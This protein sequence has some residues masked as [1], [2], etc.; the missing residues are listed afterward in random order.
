MKLYVPYNKLNPVSGQTDPELVNLAVA[1]MALGV[2]P[3][4]TD[5]RTYVIYTADNDKLPLNVADLISSKG[6]LIKEFPLFIEIENKTDNCPFL[7][8]G[9]WEDWKLDNHTFYQADDRIFIGTNAGSNS[10]MDFADL[11]PVRS[12]LKLP[13]ELPVN[14][15]EY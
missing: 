5:D 1:T 4:P 9:T 10:D 3:I 11:T 8:S 14:N 12:Q 2:K 15:L 6:V 7:E 13:S